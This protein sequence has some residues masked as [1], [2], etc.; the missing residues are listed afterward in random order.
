MGTRGGYIG[1]VRIASEI[2]TVGVALLLLATAALPSIRQPELIQSSAL[3]LVFAGLWFHVL[4]QRLLGR[5]RFVVG[6]AVVQVI[7]AY[8]IRSTGITPYF[9]YYLLPVLATVFDLRPRST[10]IV[11]AVAVAG[12]GWAVSGTVDR[13]TSEQLD[14]AFIRGFALFAVILL[15]TLVSAMLADAR[16]R[17]RRE[18]ARQ[19]SLI[20]ALDDPILLVGPDGIIGE[21]NR[22]A[23]SVFGASTRIVGRRLDDLLPFVSDPPAGEQARWAGAVPDA[24]GGTLEIEVTRADISSEEAVTSMYVVHDISRHARLNRLREQLLYNVAHELR[25]PLGVLEN[26]LDMMSGEYGEMSADDFDRLATSAQRTARRLRTLMEDLLSAGS[27]QSG[28]FRLLP[29]RTSLRGIVDGAVETASMAARERE[30][31]ISVVMPD[32]DPAALADA[33]YARQVL[34]NLLANALKYSPAGA[35]IAVCAECVGEEVRISVRDRGPGIPKDEQSGLFERFYRIRPG[36]HEPGIGLGL[37]IAK[38]IVEAH[39]GTIGIDSDIGR[40][41]TVWFTLPLAQ[42][43]VLA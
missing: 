34:A 4:P 41:T 2:A 20:A 39:G 5:D 16:A 22:A 19:R 11:G 14:V 8:L 23:A 29:E 43:P 1:Q 36:N 26:A 10:L 18:E 28:R 35:E 15:G 13:F 6:A 17:L 7:G 9:S 24:F 30:Q 32:G 31:R 33:R 3:L 21:G 25:G 42:S 27:I 40:G 12:Y 37:A 38:G